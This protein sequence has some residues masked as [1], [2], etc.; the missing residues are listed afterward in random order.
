MSAEVSAMAGE[1]T[2]NH[3]QFLNRL[4]LG[5]GVLVFVTLAAGFTITLGVAAKSLYY[6]VFCLSTVMTV[7]SLT[8]SHIY[9][10]TV[11]R[12]K[13]V[14]LV[15]QEEQSRVAFSAF[16]EHQGWNVQTVTSGLDALRILSGR[17][18]RYD[19]IITDF[20]LPTF[21]VTFQPGIP[22]GIAL[23][24]YES[25]ISQQRSLGGRQEYSERLLRVLKQIPAR[26]A[27]SNTNPSAPGLLK[28]PVEARGE[29]GV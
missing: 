18:S 28:I 11:P 4:F 20:A 8:W 6:V 9:G 12:L 22:A 3:P 21:N 29:G 17:G 26:V 15:K 14:L 2:M 24:G 16:L 13:S 27:L 19:L 1:R 7:A 23:V 25:Q 10:K 5:L